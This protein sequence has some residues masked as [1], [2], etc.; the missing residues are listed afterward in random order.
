MILVGGAVEDKEY[1]AAVSH[2]ARQLNAAGSSLVLCGRPGLSSDTSAYAVEYDN[3]G[4]AAAITDHL[5]SA[6]HT[7]I[8]YLG[9]PTALSTTTARLRGF[10]QALAARKL[11]FDPAL[12]RTGAGDGRRGP[13]LRRAATVLTITPC[14]Q[15]SV[16]DGVRSVTTRADMS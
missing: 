4:G 9:G 13:R 1:F 7:R 11:P 8:L 5:L 10:E 12:V 15:R 3:T 14:G 2:R 16:T 6:G